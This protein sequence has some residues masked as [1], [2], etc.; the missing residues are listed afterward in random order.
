MRKLVCW[1]L[2]AVLLAG[3][4]GAAAAPT[5]WGELNGDGIVNAADA[6]L[7]L[8]HAVGKSALSQQAQA[9][10]DVTGDGRIDATDALYILRYAVGRL[11]RFPADMEGM[12]ME[13]RY[14]AARDRYYGVTGADF[15]QN[16]PV[17]SADPAALLATLGTPAADG[18]MDAYEI[19]DEGNVVYDRIAREAAANG[20]LNRYRGA[21]LTRGECTLADGTRLT[22]A[23]PTAVTA[24]TAVPLTYTLTAGG[25][26]QK[27][28]VA[29]TTYEQPAR[30]PKTGMYFENTLPDKVTVAVEYDGYMQAENADVTRYPYWTESI[31]KDRPGTGYPAYDVSE[32][33]FS[34][35]LPAGK[36]T[37]LCFT[38]TNTGN[39]VLKG[40]GQ[41]YFNIRPFLYQ[42]QA[43]GDYTQVAI[44]DNYA[45]RLYDAWYPGESITLYVRF[46]NGGFAALP[47]GDYRAEL[48]CELA[49]EQNGP[50]W[51][52]M[53]VG[54]RAV[55]RSVFSFR[56]K[57]DA[58]ETAP[59]PVVSTPEGKIVRN[60]WLGVYEEFQGAYHTRLF[61]DP[62]ETVSGTLYLQPA[63]WDETLTLRLISDT[64][65]AARLVTVPLQVES[66]SLG[67]ELNPYNE[68]YVV[69]ADG[70]REPVLAT[71]NMA[72]MRGNGQD[73]P[74]ALQTIVN[75]LRDM[76]A[77]GVNYLT[78]TMAFS[79]DMGYGN[80]ATNACRIMMD[81]AARMGFA[82]EGYGM[83]PYERSVDRRNLARAFSRSNVQGNNAING[84]LNNW[85]YARFGDMFW[86]NAQGVTPIAQED[87]R[88]WLTIDHD[89]RMDLNDATVR[90]LQAWLRQ[91]YGTIDRLNEAY[92]ADFESFEAIDPRDDGA[93]DNGY[94]NFTNLTPGFSVYA[95]KSRAM[96][97][98]DLFRTVNRVEDYR[99]SLANTTLPGASMIARF[100]G[101][102]TITVGLDP[103]TANAHYRETYFQMYRAAM[104]GEILAGSG[105]VYGAST[106]TNTPYTAAETYELIKHAT[107]NGLTI[108]NFPMHYRD[109]IYNTAYGDLKAA[110]NL[111]LKDRTMR[112]TAINTASALYPVLKATYEAGGVPGVMWMDYYCSGFVTAT[113]YRELQFYTQKIR[114]MLATPAGA[115]WARD[116]DPA[117][118]VVNR[119]APHAW[120]YDTAYLDAVL[121]D[122]PPR[123][124]F[125]LQG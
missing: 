67:V 98:L 9:L 100:E 51:A 104:V 49:N 65:G 124:K 57:A 120:S 30:A 19:N 106:Y 54:G 115:A 3:S 89:W 97:D 37:W 15:N 91:A 83:Y 27:I 66:D 58:D 2:A 121:A 52:A 61:M 90:A 84:V 59:S 35:T 75:D 4:A 11:D 28:H 108:T 14:Y 38:C 79:Y 122:T 78:S 29:A 18:D 82:F 88:G 101:S 10:A 46:G 112:V 105:V 118:S 110:T 53:Y 48:V 22:Y 1:L 33:V 20:T 23:V 86:S 74:Y 87:S 55:Q 93:P 92:D 17:E 68:H 32:P 25:Q 50:A 39:T 107:Q 21:P 94:Y 40:D 72:D 73:S 44:N 36:E 114:A 16:G 64:T 81:L 119:Q 71:Q 123:D 103:S 62:G 31:T 99:Q 6:L 63:P 111:H 60:G 47:A 125:H 95:E 7:V 102:P 80:M 77:A 5:G 56:V 34:G 69:K 43:N 117:G 13:E 45:Y 113:Q 24:Y 116:F 85:I 76:Q 12:S 96:R 109:Q 70:T 41:G 42:K 26:A 8:R